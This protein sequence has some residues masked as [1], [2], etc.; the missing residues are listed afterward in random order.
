MITRRPG[1]V[2]YV[3]ANW[4]IG[5]SR[6]SWG[7]VLAG[8][9]T[10]V[11][12]SL[13]LSLLGAALGA[14]W[15]QPFNIWSDLARLGTGAVIWGIINLALSML[16]GGYVAARL[17]G[18]HSHQDAELHGLT[19][20]A[21]ATV[22]GAVLAAWLLGGLAGLVGQ[23]IG[24]FLG[25]PGG[26]VAD[27][28]ARLV[29]PEVA[30]KAVTDR[31]RQSLGSSDDL[32][33]MNRDQIRAE[34]NSLVEN[35]IA[36]DLA[37]QDYE[38]LVALVAADAG[39]TREEAARRVTRMENEARSNR[40]QIAQKARLAAETV[41]Q[42][43]S[44]AA[45]ALFTALTTGLLASLIGAWFGTRHKRAL[46]PPTDFAATTY[47]PRTQAYGARTEYRERVEPSGVAV[48]DD[49]GRLVSSYLRGL[50]FPV[51]KQDLLRAA[52][53]GSAGPAVLRSIEAM[54]ECYY[55]DINEVLDALDAAHAL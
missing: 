24:S 27:T 55:A 33:T 36:K 23:G 20:W 12:S 25:R 50:N 7:A 22:L 3:P 54:P 17:S 4:G 21:V 1:S 40:D 13:L 5:R 31:L 38:R 46:H 35:S 11:A 8:A 30:F 34:I 42:G 44:T 47:T 16:L 49:T 53:A 37:D 14:G 52:R 18:T 10:A 6:I 28:A 26:G 48:Y 32:T 15:I 2:G 29:A 51:S 43:A 45:R 9:I 41:T 19:T 39:V